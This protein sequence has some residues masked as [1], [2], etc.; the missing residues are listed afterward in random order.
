MISMN[1]ISWL[2]TV[3]TVLVIGFFQI[4]HSIFRSYNHLM[5]H[6]LST[7]AYDHCY[8]ARVHCILNNDPSVYFIIVSSEHSIQHTDCVLYTVSI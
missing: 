6:N 7:H 3:S 5:D 2:I 8:N 4:I 1:L